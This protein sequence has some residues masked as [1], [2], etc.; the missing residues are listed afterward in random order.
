[1][2]NVYNRWVCF[3][4]GNFSELL[5]SMKIFYVTSYPHFCQVNMDL[6]KKRILCISILI[7]IIYAS[8]LVL[9]QIYDT[10]IFTNDILII[11]NRY[12]GTSESITLK[13]Q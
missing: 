5:E 1:M 13:L 11:I 6:I 7:H 4:I 10:I 12:S 9:W 8:K 2:I 3:K